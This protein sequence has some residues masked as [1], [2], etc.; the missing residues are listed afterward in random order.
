MSGIPLFENGIYMN[1]GI[2]IFICRVSRDLR[3]SRFGYVSS[4]RSRLLEDIIVLLKS[5]FNRMFTP[6][7]PLVN[8]SSST[9]L[10]EA[11]LLAY[12]VKPVP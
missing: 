7:V 9:I 3:I 2:F 1:S 12:L 10:E 6:P 11:P 5:F 8:P 4:C